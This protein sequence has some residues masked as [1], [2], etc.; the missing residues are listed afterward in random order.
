MCPG[1][2]CFLGSI[3][4]GDDMDVVIRTLDGGAVAFGT[5]IVG[6][7]AGAET[8]IGRPLADGGF[9]MVS[10]DLDVGAVYGAAG[11]GIDNF[12][13]VDNY[14]IAHCTGTSGASCDPLERTCGHDAGGEWSSATTIS[15]DEAYF[16]G[17]GGRVCRWTRADGYRPANQG[18]LEGQVNGLWKH[19]AGPVLIAMSR[20]QSR[21]GALYDLDGGVWLD[22]DAGFTT[23]HGVD[24]VTWFVGDVN[25]RVHQHLADGGYR[26]L[27][28]ST[29]AIQTLYA[30]SATDV[31]AGGNGGNIVHF[32]GTTWTSLRGE[33]GFEFDGKEIIYG[34]LAGPNDLHLAGYWD[35]FNNGIQGGFWR[36]YYRGPKP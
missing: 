2:A 5:L 12:F 21:N 22:L 8:I 16:G 9:S 10:A 6:G 11:T 35:D 26:S 1:V 27:R 19:P 25:G 14:D 32:D 3:D 15:A 20:N 18:G 23:V 31:F 30:V 36:R 34:I 24:A 4:A 29:Q 7:P 28:A 33:P 17:A 13:I